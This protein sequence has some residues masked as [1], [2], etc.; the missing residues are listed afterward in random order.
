MS[1]T[2]NNEEIIICREVHKW[3]DDFHVLRGISTT[4]T[5]G[6]VVVTW[7][8]GRQGNAQPSLA[9]QALMGWREK[10]NNEK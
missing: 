4:I 10:F 1:E 7:N 8:T 9:M 6:E 3:F 2:N 5:K